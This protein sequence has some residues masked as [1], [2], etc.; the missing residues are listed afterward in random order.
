MKSILFLFSILLFI[1]CQ[2]AE[3]EAAVP[4][5]TEPEW[6][7]LFNGKDLTGWCFRAKTD[8]AATV[9]LAP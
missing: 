5:T 1:S 9:R 3:K 8:K 6:Q 7:V 4:E 2:K